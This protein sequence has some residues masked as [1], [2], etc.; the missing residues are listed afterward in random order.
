MK[1]NTFTFFVSFSLRLS[2]SIDAKED[3]GDQG[4]AKFSALAKFRNMDSKGTE[5]SS[6]LVTAVQ[7]THQNAITSFRTMTGSVGAI[8]TFSTAGKDGKL[9]LWDVADI[10]NIK[11]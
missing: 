2:G 4:Q 8:K 1:A 9:V 10:K 5:E 3:K 11:L 7:S 6:E